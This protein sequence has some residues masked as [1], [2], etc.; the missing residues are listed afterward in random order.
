MESAIIGNRPDITLI[1]KFISNRAIIIN[2]INGSSLIICNSLYRATL[3]VIHT[4]NS[5]AIIISNLC[6]GGIIIVVDR[7]NVPAIINAL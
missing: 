1:F 7:G 6:D 4:I 3:F 2:A 5:R